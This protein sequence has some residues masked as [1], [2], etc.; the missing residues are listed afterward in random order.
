M[1][2]CDSCV[3]GGPCDSTLGQVDRESVKGLI[4]DSAFLALIVGAY[5]AFRWLKK[6]DGR[7]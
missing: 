7:R 5:F 2:C 1:A 6:R 3:H 4:S